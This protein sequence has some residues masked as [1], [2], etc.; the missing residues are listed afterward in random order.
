MTPVFLL[1]NLL[2]SN[3]HSLFR[4][5]LKESGTGFSYALSSKYIVLEKIFLLNTF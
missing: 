2:E 4:H 3:R 5:S 1:E